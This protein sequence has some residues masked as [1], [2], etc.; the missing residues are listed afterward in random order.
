MKRI[1]LTIILSALVAVV[2][3]LSV[4]PIDL[5]EYRAEIK[6]RIEERINGTV[7][8]ER[9]Y[10]KL[11]PYL[12]IRLKGLRLSYMEEPLVRA[13]SAEA[14]ISILPLIFK[15]VVIKELRLEEPVITIERDPGG[16]INL[17][18][19]RKERLF[20]VMVRGLKVRN[21]SI[22]IVDS[23]PRKKMRYELRQTYLYFNIYHDVIT[24]SGE[25]ILLPDTPFKISGKMGEE[26]NVRLLTGTA[27]FE[28]L[29]VSRFLGYIKDELRGV[30]LSGIVSADIE[31]QLSGRDPF[32]GDLVIKGTASVKELTL[33]YP[34]LFVKPIHSKA[35]VASVELVKKGDH[36]TISV[37]DGRFN[38]EELVILGSVKLK[39]P[40]RIISLSLSTTPFM[41]TRIKGF[42]REDKFP[43]GIKAVIAEFR[44]VQG[45]VKL[46]RVSFSSETHDYLTSLVV[47]AELMDMAFL[48]KRFDQRFS[49]LN[50]RLIFRAGAIELE[51]I[52]GT[53]GNTRFYSIDGTL[54]SIGETPRVKLTVSADV[55]TGEL[56]REV[57]KA[58]PEEPLKSVEL[59]GRATL[60]LTM[61]GIATEPASI[62]F[63]GTVRF[64]SVRASYLPLK[65]LSLMASGTVE[66]NRDRVEIKGLSAS[67]RDSSFTVDG[68]I[69][70]YNKR[71]VLKIQ[72][73]GFAGYG[74]V[75]MY[76]REPVLTYPAGLKLRITG[77]MDSLNIFTE[78]DLSHSGLLYREIVHKERGY[79]LVVRSTVNIRKGRI[80]IKD[81]SIV[82]GKSRLHVE[83]YI[84]NSHYSLKLHSKGL[85]MEDLRGIFRHILTDSPAMG[86]LRVNL[87]LND[88]PQ[89]VSLGGKVELKDALF[90]TSFFKNSI[91][92]MNLIARFNG[93]G[94]DVVLKKAYIGRSHLSGKIEFIDIRK[95]VVSFS[96]VS[97]FLDT[98]DFIP[99]HRK[100]EKGAVKTPPRG[101]PLVAR[102]RLIAKAG[103]VQGVTFWNLSTTVAVEP[104][105]IKFEPLEFTA[106]GG[107]VSG[108]VVF[109]S[110]L[111]DKRFELVFR[112][113]RLKLS[114]LLRELG[115]KKDVLTGR[116]TADFHI[117]CKRVEP[118]ARGL[119]GTIKAVAKR[120][121]MWKFI[122]LS[123]I[124]SIVNIISITDLFEQ[125]LPY[126][127]ISGE[128]VI[129][130]GVISTE[131]LLLESK[132]L[133]MSA[134]GS[135][136]IA[137]KTID[138]K[139]GLHP[140]VT[141]DKII[142]KIPLVGWI[143]TGED[144]STITMYYEIKGPL[145][146]PEVEPIPV[147]G[148][149]TKVLGIFQRLLTSPIKVIEPLEQKNRKNEE[150]LL[151][152]H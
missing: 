92:D 5:T 140:F 76:M 24:Y 61:E 113:S 130:D 83:G 50:G 138:S 60:E 25:G 141:I 123:K 14:V 118:Y 35:G 47:D 21:A 90:K 36:L 78:V 95:R 40:Q 84:K 143:I 109:F 2:I 71:P 69:E 85:R 86:T 30:D 100:K 52:N 77:R 10:V 120:G 59:S 68:T 70:G 43:K 66:F 94:V 108:T 33:H 116:L 102:G 110:E 96:L 145:K 64:D 67:Y 15:R 146:N 51:N 65:P 55:D 37:E 114:T 115:A 53:Y 3:L 44:D 119:N 39:L 134:I 135:I 144:K 112:V 122:V 20:Y 142:S 93:G 111:T 32:A 29:R 91:R 127:K 72:A 18:K 107:H 148:L 49:S 126:R 106:H 125:G 89:G 26:E 137:E 79:P 151:E 31:Y 58:I 34:A 136:D 128:F 16:S 38:I 124:F 28:R 57:K 4:V 150:K 101:Y 117:D 131:N 82:S 104:S 73:E 99:I 7:E 103:R 74:L 132:S 88:A 19:I 98:H 87:S 41:P 9:V 13:R 42:L 149:G 133:R 1:L 81:G 129:E 45:F 54:T 23:F 75:S 11:L 63:T 27:F 17:E 97:D 6:A 8:M 121:K 46:N 152:P 139:L 48:H 105:F 22:T 62:E 80:Y 147:K 12:T 56:L